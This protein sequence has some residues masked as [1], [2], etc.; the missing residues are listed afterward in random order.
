MRWQTSLF[1]IATVRF[2]DA[3]KVVWAEPCV[4]ARATA[5]SVIIGAELTPRWRALST[6][7]AG[8]FNDSISVD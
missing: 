5:S 7:A 2:V 4:F 3:R 8:K 1:F 6:Y